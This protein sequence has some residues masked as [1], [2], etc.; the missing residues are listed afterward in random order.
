VRGGVSERIGARAS[1]ASRGP[2][3]HL[4]RPFLSEVRGYRERPHAALGWHVLFPL[5]GLG[6]SALAV[7]YIRESFRD[8]PYCGTQIVPRN[9]YYCRVFGAWGFQAK[10]S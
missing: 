2:H 9:R 8:C 3:R 1:Q 5:W 6:T 7:R 4:R 10:S